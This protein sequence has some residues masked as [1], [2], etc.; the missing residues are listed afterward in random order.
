MLE[1]EVADFERRACGEFA[2]VAILVSQRIFDQNVVKNLL[3]NPLAHAGQNDVTYEKITLGMWAWSLTQLACIASL[4]MCFPN[5]V[6]DA[7]RNASTPQLALQKGKGELDVLTGCSA[8]G[9]GGW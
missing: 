9:V 4:A 7:D 3:Y 1:L 8:S 2:T 5:S 6:D